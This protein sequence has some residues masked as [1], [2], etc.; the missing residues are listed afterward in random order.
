MLST[1]QFPQAADWM[2][3]STHVGVLLE[4][5]VPNHSLP[6]LNLGASVSPETPN[7]AAHEN[8]PSP[9]SLG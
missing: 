4:V 9:T 2:P 7:G 3:V 5:I 8:I 6:L 1:V